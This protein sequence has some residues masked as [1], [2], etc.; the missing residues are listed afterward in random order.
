VF[1]DVYQTCP[2]RRKING[3]NVK[4]RTPEYFLQ[5]IEY[6]KPQALQILTG[7]TVFIHRLGKPGRTLKNNLIL[8]VKK[9][10][11]L[12]GLA[13]IKYGDDWYLHYNPVATVFVPRSLI[14]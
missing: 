7:V 4:F 9:K 1:V 13:D 3:P 10:Q 14:N 8:L 5:G 11:L 12:I 2:I 6:R